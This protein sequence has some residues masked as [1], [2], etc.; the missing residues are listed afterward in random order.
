MLPRVRS[1]A[2]SGKGLDGFVGYKAGMT[3]AIVV[4]DADNAFKGQEVSRPVT[5]VEVPPVFVYA[6]VGYEKTQLGLKAAGQVVAEKATKF[7][8]R[9]LSVAKKPSSLEKLEKA[10][11]S[12]VRVIALTQPEKAGVG[13]KTPE[14]L[15]IALGGTDA[16]QQLEYAKSVLGKE[17]KAS[18]VFGEGDY[19]DFISVT[20]GKGWQGVVKRFGVALNPHK[21]TQ[22]RRTGGTLGP[23]RQGKIMFSV[24]RAGQMGFH[25]RVERNKRIIRVSSDAKQAAPNGGFLDYG[26]LKSEFLVVE[27][28]IAGPSRRVVRLR[29]AVS[30]KPSKKVEIKSISVQS[31][32][33]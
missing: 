32:Q 1:W 12:E 7:A 25:R 20:T 33:G 5:I 13:K 17:V 21:A 22:H 16:K 28:S 27:G 23:E 8:K 14:V 26:S 10:N 4:E 29:R 24:P 30:K 15:E 18:E 6:I 3:H 11:L 2:R 19:V 31:R 9:S